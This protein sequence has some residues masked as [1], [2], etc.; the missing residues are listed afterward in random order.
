MA[1][2]T[3]HRELRIKHIRG[4]GESMPIPELLQW[5]VTTHQDAVVEVLFNHVPV[6]CDTEYR[7]P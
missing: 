5:G 7:Y 2:S 3:H 1:T 6:C 4:A